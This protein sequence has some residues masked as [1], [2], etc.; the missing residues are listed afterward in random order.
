MNISLNTLR[1][2]SRLSRKLTLGWA[3]RWR[4][5]PLV[6]NL[7]K[8]MMLGAIVIVGGGSYGTIQEAVENAIPGDEIRID[9]GTY[10]ESVDPGRMGNAVGGGPGDLT[11]KG[12]DEGVTI[13]PMSGRPMFNSSTFS[14]NLTIHQIGFTSPNNTGFDLDDYS[15]N[16]RIN[17][18]KFNNNNENGIELSNATGSVTILRSEILD[19]GQ[20]GISLEGVE[21]VLISRVLIDGGSLSTED[22]IRGVNVHGIAIRNS[23]IRNLGDNPSDDGIDIKDPVG[24]VNIRRNVISDVADDGIQVEVNG[25]IQANVNIRRNEVSGNAETFG[26]TR[27]GIEVRTN[28]QAQLTT[29]ITGNTLSGLNDHAIE[30]AVKDASQ[31]AAVVYRNDIASTNTASAVFFETLGTATASVRFARCTIDGTNGDGVR[32]TAEDKSQ[33]DIRVERN[34]LQ[35]IGDGGGDNA[36]QIQSASGAAATIDAAVTR[37][38]ISTVGGIGLHVGGLGITTHNLT[39]RR[40]RFENT[41][42]NSGDAAVLIDDELGDVTDIHLLLERNTVGN[43]NGADAYRLNQQDPGVFEIVGTEAT[44]QDVVE[45]NNVGTPVTI[46]GKITVVSP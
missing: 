28:D 31:Q 17:K 16:L 19:M 6:E 3:T 29:R 30:V 39:V 23:T 8:R 32:V 36:I 34:V 7:Q 43:T 21:N 46:N 9:S 38:D 15:G 10:E 35:N 44:A 40:N 11:L 42:V 18:S 27:G 13:H 14:G 25:T 37:N 4:R 33:M 5:S 24:D 22:G 20:K 26:T 41:N 2:V 45:D 12:V 1:A